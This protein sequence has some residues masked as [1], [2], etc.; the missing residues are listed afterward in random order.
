[1]IGD[2]NKK[3]DFKTTPKQKKSPFINQFPAIGGGRSPVNL[4]RTRPIL[5]NCRNFVNNK[6]N[7]LWYQIWY[8][9]FK[10]FVW[11]DSVTLSVVLSKNFLPLKLILIE[12]ISCNLTI[13]NDRWLEKRRLVSNLRSLTLNLRSLYSKRLTKNWRFASK[14]DIRKNVITERLTKV[15]QSS[16]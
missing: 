13:V 2:E 5:T 9:N 11:F 6:K 7:V 16:F 8:Q 10:V 3:A 4:A 12:Q 1:M 15:L 14:M